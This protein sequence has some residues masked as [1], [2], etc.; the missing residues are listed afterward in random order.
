[1]T[2]VKTAR[3]GLLSWAGFSVIVMITG[4]GDNLHRTREVVMVASVQIFH[5][6]VTI[7]DQM[8][9]VQKNE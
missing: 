2:I 3:V 1:M 6:G 9:G 5:Q 7:A 8:H 4:P